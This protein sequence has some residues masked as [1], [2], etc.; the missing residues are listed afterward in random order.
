MENA[1]K[2]LLI[3]GGILIVMILA[4]IVLIV[5]NNVANYYASEDE[6]KMIE[7]KTKFNE[8][9]SRFN[10]D[11]VHGYE[12]ISLVNKVVDYNE[13]VSEVGNNDVK[14]K[15]VTLKV[16]LLNTGA[17]V[18]EAFLNN[19]ISYNGGLILFK[20]VSKKYQFFEKDTGKAIG[21]LGYIT[22]DAK[23]IESD[24]NNVPILIKK[25][26]KVILKSTPSTIKRVY[27]YDFSV[28]SWDWNT[29]VT[30]EIKQTE[31][32]K[33]YEAIMNFKNITGIDY[34]NVTWNVNNK[35]RR[36]SGAYA[37]MLN[38]VNKYGEKIYK[39]YE[40]TQF[41]KAIFK[42]TKLHYDETTGKIDELN[43][44]FTGKIE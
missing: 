12:L 22:N 10:R 24:I 39:Y 33:L 8:Q 2:A 35:Y 16:E 27:F 23:C 7:D 5:K 13:R 28:S 34:S 31:A 14:A 37:N 32:D 21:S 6:L 9:F 42:C 19:N 25:I 40:Y 41:K 43:F 29:G 1:S 38:D 26:D 4:S 17:G 30:D 44:R 3:A 20:D 36:I 11:D 18:T 15:P